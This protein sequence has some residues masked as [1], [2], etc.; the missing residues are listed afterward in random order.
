MDNNF[1]KE[2]T[3]KTFYGDEGSVSRIFIECNSYFRRY[4]NLVIGIYDYED[5][6]QI[7]ILKMLKLIKSSRIAEI[8]NLNGYMYSMIRNMLNELIRRN[9]NDNK[10]ISIDLC[11]GN[12]FF[13]DKG[14]NIEE[15]C[16]RNDEMAEMKKVIIKAMNK[17]ND[18]ERDIV[19]AYY[20][21]EIS[22]ADYSRKNKLNYYTCTKRLRR[23]ENKM[24]KYIL[25]NLNSCSICRG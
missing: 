14:C 6:R 18:N 8:K 25:K 10:S 4:S 5:F 22:I 9:I 3:K 11:M 7:F 19:K 21:K 13:I 12:M 24:L 23:T 16:I 2:F 17:L 15:E 1:F 20:F